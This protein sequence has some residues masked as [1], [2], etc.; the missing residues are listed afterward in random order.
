M[1]SKLNTIHQIKFKWAGLRPVNQW[2]EFELFYWNS[3]SSVEF[4]QSKNRELDTVNSLSLEKGD[5]HMFHSSL[6]MG[7]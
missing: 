6:Y 4:L 1:Q 2:L 3:F 5:S 7:R